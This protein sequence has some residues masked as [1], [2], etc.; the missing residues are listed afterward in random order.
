MGQEDKV[1][2][3]SDLLELAT[4]AHHS[5]EAKVL[6]GHRDDRWF[7]WYAEYL[8]GHGIDLILEDSLASEIL[9]RLLRSTERDR[10]QGQSLVD[11][12]EVTAR[13]IIEELT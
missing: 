7:D 5:Y 12:K 8:I 13:R 4:Q 9:G 3:V 6:K 2:Q 11:W 10:G 1:R